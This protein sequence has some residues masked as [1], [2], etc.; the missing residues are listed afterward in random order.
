VN[1]LPGP[2]SGEDAVGANKGEAIAC[3]AAALDDVDQLGAAA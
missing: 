1:V 2:V 3:V